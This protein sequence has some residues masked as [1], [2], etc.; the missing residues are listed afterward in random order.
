[1][2][3][4]TSR[5]KFITFEG[6]DGCGKTTQ[7]EM[8]LELLEKQELSISFV[9]EPGGDPISESI[10][11][12]LLHS[13]EIMSDRAEALLMIASRAQLTDKVILPHLLNGRWMIADRYADST[14]AYQGGGRGLNSTALEEINYF[15][16][17]TLKPDLTFFIDISVEEANKRM[18]VS[19]DRI[20]KEGQ[21]FQQR[22][23]DFYTNLHTKE[24]ERVMLINGENS[25][26]AIH[27]EISS[28]VSE[29]L[30]S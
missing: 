16:T 18:S 12:L 2:T 10:R 23:R 5:G 30:I 3:E 24:P 21:E 15:G 11:K 20:E 13:E 7:A 9:R 25:I 26:D 28:I 27:N 1:M 14:L 22:V 8:L 6:I 4:S 17:Y 19:R 29:K